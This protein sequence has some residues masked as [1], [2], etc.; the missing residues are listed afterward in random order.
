[1]GR[2]CP[3]NWR[4]TAVSC[5]I[6]GASLQGY[7]VAQEKAGP[8]SGSGPQSTT[9]PEF[10]LRFRSFRSGSVLRRC[11][12]LPLISLS[13]LLTSYP[14]PH[15]QCLAE[16]IELHPVLLQSSFRWRSHGLKFSI[17]RKS[18]FSLAN[19]TLILIVANF[20]IAVSFQRRPHGYKFFGTKARKFRS[21]S[22]AIPLSRSPPNWLKLVTATYC[23]TFPIRLSGDVTSWCSPEG[24]WFSTGRMMA[25]S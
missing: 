6:S 5:Q 10:G 15:D 19:L 9:C 14:Y 4:G 18:H 25:W 17:G 2:P 20:V 16:S 1:M 12:S 3:E 22:R 24:L 11:T 13:P 23:W 7:V 21:P 8:T